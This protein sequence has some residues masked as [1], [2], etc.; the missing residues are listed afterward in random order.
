MYNSVKSLTKN[1][2]YHI[3]ASLYNHHF[4][5]TL[6]G[7]TVLTP[8]R[9]SGILC[10]IS[11][12]QY[13]QP[14][15]KLFPRTQRLKFPAQHSDWSTVLL[16]WITIIRTLNFKT[17]LNQLI[18]VNLLNFISKNLINVYKQYWTW[19]GIYLATLKIKFNSL[20]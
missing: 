5:M 20:L 9:G 4:T 8:A 18:T 16:S 15:K 17:K 7:I 12:E 6:I 19:T 1:I 3:L 11:G 14:N 13:F 10:S 2:M